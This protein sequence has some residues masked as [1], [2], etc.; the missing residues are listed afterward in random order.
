MAGAQRLHRHYRSTFLQM[1]GTDQ[2]FRFVDDIRQGGLR[3]WLAV[4]ERFEDARRHNNDVTD[5][6]SSAYYTTQR[7]KVAADVGMI[8]LGTVVPMGWAANSAV[9]I[10][11]SIACKFA[12]SFSE[13]GSAAMVSFTSNDARDYTIGTGA[14]GFQAISD[15]PAQRAF[16]AEKQLFLNSAREKAQALGA[17]LAHRVEEVLA[18]ELHGPVTP[19]QRAIRQAGMGTLNPAQQ[20]RLLAPLF[21]ASVEA[22]QA[23]VA[24]ERAAV[25]RLQLSGVE[26]IRQAPTRGTAVAGAAVRGAAVAVGLWFMREDIMTALVGATET[27]ARKKRERL[28]TLRGE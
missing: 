24:A 5:L 10:G 14:N 4:Q 13:A 8:V 9:G 1:V 2:Q 15:I 28:A 22:D 12:R 11:Y 6:L 21:H 26:A 17:K 19:V 7:V 16:L 3:S 23:V 25:A 18:K 20:S 27:E